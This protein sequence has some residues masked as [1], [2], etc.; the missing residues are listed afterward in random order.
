M[1]E[2]YCCER[3][4]EPVQGLSSLGSSRMTCGWHT[5]LEVS[6]CLSPR[7]SVSCR[8]AWISWGWRAQREGCAYETPG[9]ACEGGGMSDAP[10]ASLG[11]SAEVVAACF[12]VSTGFPCGWGLMSTFCCLTRFD[13]PS[14]SWP[15]PFLRED[16]VFQ[17]LFNYSCSEQ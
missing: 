16:T 12:N 17:C 4:S 3:T 6:L 8:C 15:F 13:Y 2:L 5:R 11:R 14:A 10:A 1:W 9:V 7:S